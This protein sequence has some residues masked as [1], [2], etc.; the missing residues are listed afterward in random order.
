MV[1]LEIEASWESLFSSL[2]S[3]ELRPQCYLVNTDV[4]HLLVIA[5]WSCE[6]KKFSKKETSRLQFL[7]SCSSFRN[8]Q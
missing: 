7:G 1:M 2:V 6:D 3:G 5:Q 4:A 8:L